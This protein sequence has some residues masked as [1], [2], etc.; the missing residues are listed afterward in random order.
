MKGSKILIFNSRKPGG[1]KA[2]KKTADELAND[3]SLLTYDL[4]EEQ[5]AMMDK[6]SKY[7]IEKKESLRGIIPISASKFGRKGA[8]IKLRDAQIDPIFYSYVNPRY[9]IGDS[10]GLGKT[11]MSAACY[12]YYKYQEFRNGRV[13]KKI[14]V[15]TEAAHVLSFSREWATYG[16]NIMPLTGSSVGVNKALKK[17]NEDYDNYDGIILN[18]DGLKTNGFI[19]YYL[20]HSEEY[21]YGVFDET[22]KLLNSKS[23]LYKVTNAVIN[24]YDSGLKHT[25][26]LNGSSFEKSI[27]DFFYQFNIL[28]PKLI[29]SKSF[30][31]ARYVIKGGKEIYMTDFSSNKVVKRKFGTIVDYKNQAELKERLRYYYIARSKADYSS[32]LPE[33]SYILHSLE[34][35]EAQ[36]KKLAKT[37]NMF[38]INSPKTSDPTAS[39]TRKNSPKL[40][41]LLNFAVKVEDDRP[42]IYVY[43]KESQYTIKDELEKLGYR[44]GLLNGDCSVE[45]KTETVTKFNNYELDMLVFNIQKAIN[46]P[47]S[48]RILFYDVPTMPQETNQIKARIDRN[49]YTD[50]KFYDFFIYMESPEM[51]NMARLAYFREHHGNEFTGQVENVYGMLVTQLVNQLEEEQA[52]ALGETFEWMYANKKEYK[53]IDSKVEDI[54]NIV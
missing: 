1:T 31:D 30:L 9:F 47:T 40:D 26:F 54:L 17:M 39:F 37:K 45:D 2:A 10:P 32:D 22:S 14:I 11:V 43:N 35:T 21:D 8:N 23:M 42:M 5:I 48:N 51:I 53:D 6:F 24:E 46:V 27:Y 3:N 19:E 49:N 16:I 50:K 44:V 7:P 18:W 15:V 4:G 33:H 13:P 29:P 20:D 25:I 28:K 41:E 52:T 36:R 12:A 38:A 34:L